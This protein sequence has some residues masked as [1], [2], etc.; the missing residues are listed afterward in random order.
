MPFCR[1]HHLKTWIV[2]TLN[3][4]PYNFSSCRPKWL[5]YLE[6]HSPQDSEPSR[7][8]ARVSW[9]KLLH[10]PLRW[11]RGA[12]NMWEIKPKTW[13]TL[14]HEILEQDS[15]WWKIRVSMHDRLTCPTFFV[16]NFW[17][18]IAFDCVKEIIY[19]YCSWLLW[20]TLNVIGDSP[21]PFFS[22]K[23]Q[24]NTEAAWKLIK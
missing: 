13:V 14:L 18:P 17:N 19:I 3:F 11:A 7:W 15:L 9:P 24:V 2:A 4:T 5:R 1:P 21:L 20:A 6:R 23:F 22:F 8:R 12:G 16:F 10:K